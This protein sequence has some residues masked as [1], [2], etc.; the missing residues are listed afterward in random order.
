MTLQEQIEQAAKSYASK[1]MEDIK[2]LEIKQANWHKRHPNEPVPNMN[3]RI[4]ACYQFQYH[5]YYQGAE[6]GY[7]LAVE[8][9]VEW[10]SKEY[11]N[12]GMRYI[13]GCSPTDEIENFKKAMKG[14]K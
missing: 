5:A 3:G 11:E 10:L 9:A 2:K 14:E 6:Y 4:L 8:K 1:F 7:K 12:I 13:R